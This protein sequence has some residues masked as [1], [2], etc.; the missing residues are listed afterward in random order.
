MPTSVSSRQA[1]APLQCEGG[2]EEAL[3]L[4]E[5]ALP[6]PPVPEHVSGCGHI[7]PGPH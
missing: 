6:E 2:T 5:G 1:L 7:D 3:G 4:L